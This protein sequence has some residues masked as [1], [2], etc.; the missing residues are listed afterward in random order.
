M[1]RLVD[2]GVTRLTWV[3]GEDGIADV[4]APTVTELEAGKDLT[5]LMVTTYEVR[6]NGSD[7]T[8][9]RSVA[10]VANVD[11]PTIAN[12]M[13]RFDLF[14]DWDADAG[15]FDPDDD[16]LNFLQYKDE[17]YFVRR[18]GLPRDDDWAADQQVEVYKFMA[19]E[20][21]IQGGTGEG[22]LKA[23][24]P[25]FQRGVYNTRATVANGS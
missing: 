12:Y 11:T 16:V 5:H 25:L 24:V 21:Q 19:D 3:P 4:A 14:R 18:L 22:N 23:T 13:G 8:A 15:E 6:T 17:G 9:E 1:P 2:Q 10:D 7:T 20:P